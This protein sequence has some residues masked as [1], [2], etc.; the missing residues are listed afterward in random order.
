ME[1]TC[2]WDLLRR[3]PKEFEHGG[4]PEFTYFILFYLSE[5]KYFLEF[6]SQTENNKLTKDK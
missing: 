5:T 2:Y 6:V 3:R 4:C 1:E